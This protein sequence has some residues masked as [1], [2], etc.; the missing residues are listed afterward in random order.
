MPIRLTSLCACVLTLLFLG[1][2]EAGAE[3]IELAARQALIMDANTGTVLLEKNADE[4]MTPSSMSKLMT[5]YMVFLR[6]K[7][8]SLKMTDQLPVTET[9]WKKH[10]K[11]EGS[12]MFLPVNAMVRVDD[13]LRG[14]II[15][16]GNDAC[17]VLAEGLAGSEEAFAEQATRKAREIG[18]TKSTFRNASGWPE[19]GHKMTAHDLAV[20]ARRL[21]LDFP[22]YYPIFAEK[23]FVYNNIKQDNRNPLIWQNIPGADGLKTGHTEEGGYGEVGSAIREGRRIIMVMNGMSSIRERAEE[24][25]RVI[26]WAFREFDDFSLFK[27]GDPVTD[28]EVWL[29]TSKSVPLVI[30]EDVTVTLP[31]MARHDMKVTAQFV[32]PLPSPVVKGTKIGTVVITAPGVQDISVPLLTGGDVDRLGFVGRVGTAIRRILWG[33]NS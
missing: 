6:L 25:Q 14:V 23:T 20:L 26:E 4:L 22:D 21:I 32:G 10:Y 13:L 12:L 9:A 27:A 7:E 2:S 16:S 31:R 5:V 29:G 18:M 24:S 3:P 15:Q 28:A 17:S 19:P 8:G 11:T 1:R 33:A 30:G